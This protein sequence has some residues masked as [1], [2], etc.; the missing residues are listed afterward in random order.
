MAL[1]V[2]ES[3]LRKTRSKG[4]T[5]VEA[6]IAVIVIAVLMFAL[7]LP[8][9]SGQR[10]GPSR[11]MQ[12]STKIRGIH[13]SMFTYAQSNNEYLPGITSNGNIA[14]HGAVGTPFDPTLNGASVE[15]RYATLLANDAFE[16]EYLISSLETRDVWTDLTQPVT[17]DNYSFALLRIHSDATSVGDA[18]ANVEP[19]QGDRATVWR[20]ELGSETVL[21]GDRSMQNAS[22]SLYSIHTG[23]PRAGAAHDWRGTIGWADN[24]VG[25]ETTHELDTKYGNGFGIANDHLFRSDQGTAM[26]AESGDGPW[27]DVMD[28]ANAVLD[29]VGSSPDVEATRMSGE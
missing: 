28:N 14:D 19:D 2:Y 10:R 16:G 21:L 1:V 8:A 7:V 26:F 6:A 29:A 17:E 12:N 15:H 22:G 25:F 4:F 27:D 23:E 20:S 24:H 9:I 18:I 13:Q 3:V 11:Q 5:A